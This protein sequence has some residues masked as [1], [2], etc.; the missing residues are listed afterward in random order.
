MDIIK[1]FR[2]VATICSI[3]LSMDENVA[4][5]K[6]VNCTN[7]SEIKGRE[8]Y[9]FKIT[10]N[11]KVKPVRHGPY[12]LPGKKCNGD[13]REDCNGRAWCSKMREQTDIKGIGTP[14][15]HSVTGAQIH[16]R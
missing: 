12:M 8:K 1:I 10:L 5:R 3:W 6:A 14:Q 4:N 15:L 7:I 9:L 2:K 16:V 13:K 11:G